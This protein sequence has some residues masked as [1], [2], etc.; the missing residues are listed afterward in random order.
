V[1]N[2]ARSKE[3][4]SKRKRKKEEEVM[5]AEEV[6]KKGEVRSVAWSE[7]KTEK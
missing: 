6:E 2:N 3:G 5:K 1:E 7:K 4:K